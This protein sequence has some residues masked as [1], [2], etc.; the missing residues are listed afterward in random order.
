MSFKLCAD[1]FASASTFNSNESLNTQIKIAIL[2]KSQHIMIKSY[3][4]SYI[5]KPETTYQHIISTMGCLVGN[6][7]TV[8]FLSCCSNAICQYP[9]RWRGLVFG[10]LSRVVDPGTRYVN[11]WVGK[12]YKVSTKVEMV[13]FCCRSTLPYNYDSSEDHPLVDVC[14][15]MYFNIIDPPLQLLNSKTLGKVFLEEFKS[16]WRY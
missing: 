5:N 6:F 15:V 8:P 11:P 7:G 1:N 3:A 12:I 4:R 14:A 2:Y 13:E 16:H 10:I 9:S